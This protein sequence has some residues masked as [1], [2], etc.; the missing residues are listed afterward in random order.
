MKKIISFILCA[1]I[2]CASLTSLASSAYLYGDINRDG[3]INANDSVCILQY[4][5]YVG[6]GGK[7]SLEKFLG[8]D[9]AVGMVVYDNNDIRIS[10]TGFERLDYS[11][12]AKFLVENNSPNDITVY[13]RD[14]SLNGFMADGTIAEKVASGKKSNC[15]IFFDDYVLEK[16]GL[17]IADVNSMEFKFRIESNKEYIYSDT[18]NLLFE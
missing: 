1:A 13:V 11:F 14:E 15:Y 17:S 16:A 8:F 10:Y 4:S 2:S 9:T 12:H 5:A 3:A 6:T 7:D 18:I